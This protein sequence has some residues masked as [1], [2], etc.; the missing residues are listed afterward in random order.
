MPSRGWVVSP[1]YRAGIDAI[2]LLRL[3]RG[4]SLRDVAAALDKPHSWVQKIETFERRLDFLEF[5]ALARALG[6][7]PEELLNRVMSA[8]PGQFKV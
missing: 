7:E 3:E 2:K 4:L 5:V 6:I 8:L 1:A